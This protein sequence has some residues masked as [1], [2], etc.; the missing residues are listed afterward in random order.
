MKH[1][2]SISLSVLYLFILSTTES[3]SSNNDLE[4]FETL[5][6][7]GRES[8]A[9]EKHEEAIAT[10]KKA[11]EINNNNQEV[12]V[13]I[14]WGYFN[15]LDA[16]NAKLNWEK[17][18]QISPIAG[19]HIGIGYI[20]FMENKLNQ[21]KN[22]FVTAIAL[23][24]ENSAAHSALGRLYEKEELYK[25]AIIEL[26]KAIS[27]NPKEAMAHFTLSE[28]YKEQGEINLSTKHREKALVI[29]EAKK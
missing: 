22:H 7:K 4:L 27:L 29:L 19:A 3:I 21:A 26:D 20:Y 6:K 2:L 24:P 23:D 17:A 11:I 10:F 16:D 28:I 13:E 9:E 14:G 12:Y 18:N 1:L 8:L 25:E 5:V 15:L